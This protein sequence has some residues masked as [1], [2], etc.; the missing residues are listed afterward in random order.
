MLGNEIEGYISNHLSAKYSFIFDPHIRGFVYV[1]MT[2]PY[3]KVNTLSRNSIGGK[4]TLFGQKT[5]FAINDCILK[6]L[7]FLVGFSQAT[8]GI[9]RNPMQSLICYKCRSSCSPPLKRFGD[10]ERAKLALLLLNLNSFQSKCCARLRQPF[11][12]SILVASFIPSTR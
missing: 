12:E 6:L 10:C 11:C 3:Q 1:C 9:D 5:K 2:N 7:Y 4:T 8:T